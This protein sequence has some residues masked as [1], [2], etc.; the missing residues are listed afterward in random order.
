MTSES[1]THDSLITTTT[2]ITVPP[3]PSPYEIERQQVL[4]VVRQQLQELLVDQPKVK[5]VGDMKTLLAIHKDLYGKED[6]SAGGRPSITINVGGLTRLSS[7]K[8]KR[9][10]GQCSE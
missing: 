5:S 6:K 3:P 7:R 10:D 9:V 2:A 8:E 4:R 1:K